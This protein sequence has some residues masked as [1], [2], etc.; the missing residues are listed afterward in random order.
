MSDF[1]FDLLDPRNLIYKEGAFD[2]L[3]QFAWAEGSEIPVAAR[4]NVTRQEP[5]SYAQMDVHGAEW[6][7]F[8][9]AEARLRNY[10]SIFIR[11]LSVA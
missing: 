6:C 2:V 1:V 11:Y 10:A 9:V 3:I 8:D 4:L 7:S 5:H